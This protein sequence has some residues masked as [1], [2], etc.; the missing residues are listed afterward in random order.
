[1]VEEVAVS[2]KWTATALNL[3]AQDAVDYIL[4]AEKG[5]AEGQQACVNRARQVAANPNSQ[6]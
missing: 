4:A 2:G 5:D 1:M 6:E 3:I